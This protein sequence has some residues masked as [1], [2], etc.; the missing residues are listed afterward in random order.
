[1]RDKTTVQSANIS[2]A[3]VQAPAPLRLK[4]EKVI[5]ILR[6][7]DPT[8]SNQ[9]PKRQDEPEGITALYE[10]LSKDDEQTFW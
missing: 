7:N 4:D 10:R 2:F 6:D 9:Q 1:M 5:S 3:R 8:L